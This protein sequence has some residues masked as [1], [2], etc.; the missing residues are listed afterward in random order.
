MTR[1]QWCAALA[2]LVSPAFPEDAQVA[3][4]DMLPA[5][6]HLPDQMFNGETLI[7]VA[8]TKTRQSVP[9]FSELT[10]VLGQY[11]AK[12]AYSNLIAAPPNS[13]LPQGRGEPP[14]EEVA[15]VAKLLS[16]RREEIQRKEIDRRESLP[17][18]QKLPDVS[19]KGEA[20]RLSRER[21]GVK[22]RA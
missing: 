13:D 1:H 21:R 22:V 8:Q 9:S 15:Y 16:D 17:P 20:L 6:G 5:L 10:A 3:L 19:L 12:V 7:A 14:M 18:S 4:I 2:K 11:R